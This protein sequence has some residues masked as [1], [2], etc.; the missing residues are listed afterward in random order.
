M[1]E[2]AA[3]AEPTPAVSLSIISHGHGDLVRQLLS[4]LRAL[5]WP[6][7]SYEVLLTVNIPES[8]VNWEQFEDL[9]LFL[10]VNP[11]PRGFGSNHNAA[12]KRSRG[13]AF[14]ILNPDVRLQELNLTRWLSGLNQPQVGAC[15]PMATDSQ[16]QLQDNARSFPSLLSLARRVITG[17]RQPSYLASDGKQ[18]IDWAAGYFL[19]LRREAFEQIGGFDE[20][21]FMYMEDVDLGRR[22]QR[23]GWKLLWDP[24]ICIVHDARRASHHDL[25]HLAWHINGV[26][27]FLWNSNPR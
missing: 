23:R 20:H 9:P 17:Q 22:L 16:G 10:A 18:F 6:R 15:A 14:A 13:R 8:P 21:Y 7:D 2:T 26:L 1:M 11:Q 12:F 3:A 19:L 27:R 24:S 4:D 25:R 5:K